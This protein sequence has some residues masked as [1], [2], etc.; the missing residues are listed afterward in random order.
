MTRQRFIATHG[1]TTETIEVVSQ[2]GGRYQVL[3]DGVTHTVDARRFAAG[4]W[5]LLI[6]D[7]S[8]DVEL[9]VA[10]PTES[11]GAYNTLVRGKVVSLTV[12]DERL[13]RMGLTSKRFKVEGPQVITAPMPGKVL[14][15]LVAPG[16]TVAEGQPLLI[17]EAMKMENELR[18]PKAGTVSAVFVRAG[19]AVEA[20]AR[21]ASV[22]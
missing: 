10:G 12:Q 6:D 9:E 1:A 4:T 15:L 2:G 11:K 7:Q 3:L 17:M 18:A 20:H 22:D 16:D 19:Q 14:E 13:V 21:L 8:Y 5:S